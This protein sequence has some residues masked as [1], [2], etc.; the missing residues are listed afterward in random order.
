MP[1]AIG[2][3]SDI[4][5]MIVVG[6]GGEDS[7]EQFAYQVG[8]VVACSG[9]SQEDIE[10]ADNYWSQMVKETTY[11]EYREAADILVNILAV[12][13]YTGLVV[14]EENNWSALSREFDV[15]NMS[16]APT[17]GEVIEYIYNGEDRLSGLST[18]DKETD[19]V[20]EL[21]SGSSYNSWEPRKELKQKYPFGS[22]EIN[23][24]IY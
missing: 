11:S 12:V 7:I 22:M 15:I 4:A 5:F 17:K 1:K 13:D 16:Y 9:G 2:Q 10:N 24:G 19:F 23:V 21:S 3:I 20:D 18:S 14:L 8:Q 6:G